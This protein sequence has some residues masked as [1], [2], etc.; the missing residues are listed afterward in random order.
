MSRMKPYRSR[1]VIIALFLPVLLAAVLISCSTLERTVMVAPMIEG[2]TFVGNKACYE[3]HTEITRIFPASPHA[4]LHFEGALMADSTG[5][6]SCHGPGSKHIAGGGG[7]GKFIVNPG[8]D[9]AACF[10]CHRTTEA[11]FH[12]PQHHPLLEGKLACSQSH[13]PHGADIFNPASGLAI[14]RLH[15]TCNSCHRDQT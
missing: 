3:C 11:E 10:E 14:A 6:E 12:L 5:C 4:R 1:V 7:R 8:K 15:A 9:P 2:A 13:D